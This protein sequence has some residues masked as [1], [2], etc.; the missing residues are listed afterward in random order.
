MVRESM[1]QSRMASFRVSVGICFPSSL[2][3]SF[4]VFL[5]LAGCRLMRGYLSVD[6][7]ACSTLVSDS[8]EAFRRYLYICLSSCNYW[9]CGLLG[10]GCMHDFCCFNDLGWWCVSLFLNL[11]KSPTVT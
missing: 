9:C 6:G 7:I 10:S 5:Y 4:S 11:I 8:V 3:F 1:E 2:A